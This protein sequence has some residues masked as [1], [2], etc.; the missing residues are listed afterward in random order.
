MQSVSIIFLFLFVAT[1]HNVNGYSSYQ[2]K[3]PNGDKIP[4]PCKPNSIWT[5]VGHLNQFGAGK[6]NPFGNAFKNAGYT[7][8]KS[9]CEADSDGDGKKN[10]EE[11]GDPDC[12]WTEGAQPAKTSGLSH[13]GVCEPVDSPKCNSQ[14]W[15]SCTGTK[16]KCPG[17]TESGVKTIDVRFPKW[18]VPAQETTYICK[19]FKLPSDQDYHIVASDPILDNRNVIHHMIIYGCEG[20]IKIEKDPFNCIMGSSRCQEFL[21]AWTVGA[22]GYCLPKQTGVRFGKT[23]ARFIQLQMH[24]TNDQKKTDYYD[25]SG[26]KIYYTP[27]LRMYDMGTL[28]TG[29]LHLE[30]PPGQKEIVQ[31]GVCPAA[32]T[33]TVL[34]TNGINITSVVMHA[35]FLGKNLTLAQYRNG[36]FLRMLGNDDA[37]S[38]NN[39]ASTEHKPPVVMLPGDELKTTCKFNTKTR[40]KTTY[41]GDGTYDEMCF[42]FANYYPKLPKNNEKLCISY[43]RYTFC[44]IARHKNMSFYDHNFGTCNYTDFKAQRYVENIL[45]ACGSSQ[46]CEKGCKYYVDQ[47]NTHRCSKG[48]EKKMLR[49]I[50]SDENKVTAN[51]VFKAEKACAQKDPISGAFKCNLHCS[52]GSPD[53]NLGEIPRHPIW[54]TTMQSVSIIFLFLFVATWHNVNGYSSYQKKIP[55]G[56]KIPHP[57]KPNSIWT[58]VGH[59]NQFGAGK[60]NPFGNAFKNAGYTWTKS[61]CEADSDGDGKKNGEEL[62]DPDCVW[63][64]GAQPAKTSGLSH[65]GVCEPVDS[66]KCN[67]QKWISC[68]GTKEKCPGRTESGVKTIDVRF[69]KWKVP[70][71]ETTYMCKTFELP[72]DQDYHIVASDPILDNRNV[73]HHMIIYGCD[74]DKKIEKDPFNC[75]MGSARCQEM[76][77]GWTVGGE[78]YCLPEKTGVRFGKTAAK[79][80][81]LQVHWT[82]DQKKTN[83]YDSSGF[84]IYYTPKLRMYDMGKLTVGQ[85]QLELPPGQKQVIETAVCPAGCTRTMLGSN[86]NGI[87]ITSVAMHAHFLGKNLTLAQYRNGKFLRMLGIDDAFNYNSPTSTEHRPAVVMLPG[88]ELKTTCKFNTKTRSKTTYYG[89][90]TF[91]EMCFAFVDYYPKIAKKNEKL[92]ISYERY[93]LCDRRIHKNMSYYDHNFGTCNFTE[94]NTHGYTE[95]I[96]TACGSSRKCEKQCKYYVD[97]MNAHRCS[98]GFEKKILRRLLFA[99]N[100][101]TARAVWRSE[102]ACAQKGPISGAFKQLEK[103]RRSDLENNDAKIPNGDKIPHPCKPNS[104]W[105]GVGHLN[106]FGAGKTNPF[107]NAF[108]NAGHT[109]T[110][111][112]CEAD[113]DGDGKKN[114]EELGDP[115]C[116]WTQGAQPAKTSGLSH[117]GVCEPVDSPKC[118]SQKWIS[119]T[120]TKEKCP[121]RTESGVKT[122]DVRFPKWKVPAQETTYLCKTFELPSDQDYHIVASDPI[123]DNRNV[124]HHMIIYGCDGDMKIEKDPFNCIMGS[125][126]C[127]EMLVGWTVG[128]EGYCL[129]EK[130]GVRFGK[131][132]AKFIQLQVHWTNDQKKTN[133]HDSSGF[134]IYYTPKL[135]MYDIGTLTIGQ[136]HLELPPG[137]KQVIQRG[138]CPAGCTR[139]MLGS[140]SNGINITGVAMH[141]H[142]L[143]KNLTLAQYRN[144]KFLR[145]LGID[146]A[147][148]YNNPTSTRHKPAVVMLPGDE[149]RTTCKFNTKTRSKTTYYGDGT[150]DEMCF[151][152]VDYYPK[153]PKNNEKLCLSY[154]RYTMCDMSIHNNATYYS[155]NFGTCNYTEFST[156]GYVKN[157]LRNCGSSQKCEKQCKY[158]VDQMNAHRC[159]KGFEKKILRGIQYAENNVTALAV[160]KIEED[161]AQQGPISGAFKVSALPQYLIA[162]ILIAAKMLT[163]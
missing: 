96:L 159:S 61:L 62:G 127:Q 150:Y 126:R 153:I 142:F 8:T 17:R 42:G 97:Q 136:L 83:Y 124:I 3:I 105:T 79:F 66:P 39:P 67:S 112:L 132:A 138:V 68:T 22:E 48:Y 116:V 92:C 157:I 50:L 119:C 130:T 33:R 46:K 35:H 49:R 82:N 120:G 158:Y 28:S 155:H 9:L 38:Y 137:Q 69:P 70:A 36:Q 95:N 47:M 6:R 89:D 56:D 63:T 129:P 59:L 12:V 143:G 134:K 144:G 73:I 45:R 86:S 11:L 13:P 34:R 72:S 147:F 81:Q 74:G 123:L 128:G 75:I 51:G 15:I 76:L 109:W 113:S 60:T 77:V 90:G 37:F 163:G 94:F 107:G 84:K 122:I 10:G 154:E 30:L 115:D 65:P 106:Q 146:D 43:E 1:W 80:I 29:Q 27:K 85:L 19:S 54:R 131:T 125:A 121:G 101:V 26:F 24:W 55:N 133:Y 20:D 88:D 64:E 31:T 4:H 111:S 148:N 87:N 118:N 135:R 53:S 108:K 58:G 41:Y 156:H 98:K 21:L 104:I 152:F 14:K 7:W 57:C 139:T 44:D 100:N 141:A 99:E 2:K 32:C 151:A 71:Q 25:S 117:P 140:N 162:I 91:D 114:G 5:G 160:W 18:K 145:M 23:A 102:E 149:L 103:I 16:E 93:T 40:S 78:G 52:S 161:C 110:K